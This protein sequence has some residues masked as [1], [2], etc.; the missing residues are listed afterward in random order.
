MYNFL[1]MA[2]SGWR[3]IALLVLIIAIANYLIGWFRSDS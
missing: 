1:L 2:H 3:Y